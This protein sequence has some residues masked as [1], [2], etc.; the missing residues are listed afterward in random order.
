MAL[1]AGETEAISLALE[2][3]VPA[4]LMDER[5]GRLAAE[6]R[7]LIAVGTLNILDAADEAGLLVFTDALAKLE[8]TSFRVRPALAAIFRESVQQR[9]ERR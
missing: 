5:K 4:V 6:S 3:G 7:G 8:R 1:G 9:K 2:I